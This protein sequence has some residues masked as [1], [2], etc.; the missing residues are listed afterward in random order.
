MKT[1][2]GF[3]II[4]LI[5]VVATIAVLAAIVLSNVN[6]YFSKA[7]DAKRRLDVSQ[8]QRA[9]EMYYADYGTYPIATGATSPNSGWANSADASWGSLQTA[10]RPYLSTL[11]KDPLENNNAAEWGA[12]GYHYSYVGSCG[13]TYML[14]FRLETAS[15][16][17]PGVN[18]C[19]TFY[20][21]GGGG[22]STN[23]KTFGLV[24]P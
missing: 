18:Y 1:Q 15:G 22:A 17:D 19:G 7:R 2:K 14:V 11:A 13:K 21:Y 23:V 16:T 10:L 3:T 24:K 5:V 6:Q 8:I 12:S 9:L 4:E 20:Q